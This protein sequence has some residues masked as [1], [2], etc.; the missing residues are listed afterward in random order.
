MKTIRTIEAATHVGQKVRL[1]GWLHTLRRMGGVNFIILRDG[2]GTLQAVTEQASALA[3]LQAAEAGVESI[4]AL[5]GLVVQSPQAPGGV[6]LHQPQLGLI[7]AV[8]DSPPVQINKR[9]IKANLPTLLDQAVITNRHPQRRAIFRL[10]A[11]VMAGFRATLTAAGFTE[12]Q[13][14]KIV[15]SATESGAN[16]FTLDYFGQRAYLAQS[17]QFYKQIM[18]GVFERVFE[19]GP[20][21]P[22]R[23]PRY[24]PPRKRVCQPGR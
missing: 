11:G 3:P 15:A 12:V 16:V 4:I 5:E 21:F 19:V 1:Q 13:T 2:W 7:S 6:E 10:A 24:L 18:V 22:S 23:T 17:P 20:V 14:P 8:R 9:E